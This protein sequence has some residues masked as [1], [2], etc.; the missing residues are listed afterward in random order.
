[1]FYSWIIACSFIYF[2]MCSR[3]LVYLSNC[4]PTWKKRQADQLT[5]NIAKILLKK[6]LEAEQIISETRQ[7]WLPL[8][9]TMPHL[10]DGTGIS[11]DLTP[12]ALGGGP[13]ECGGPLERDCKEKKKLTKLTEETQILQNIVLQRCKAWNFPQKSKFWCVERLTESIISR[14]FC[15][16]SSICWGSPCKRHT[17]SGPTPLSAMNK[18][19]RIL[20][21][22]YETLCLIKIV[23]LKKILLP[24]HLE[25]YHRNQQHGP[26][27]T[28]HRQAKARKIYSFN[29]IATYAL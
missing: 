29:I 9:M 24:Q 10:W 15:V 6:S 7:L 27:L 18:K 2:H 28:H 22:N 20:N 16:A 14:I 4:F 23:F 11:M 17:R 5:E 3:N 25:C 1:M 8:P 21:H 12:G 26:K 19:G 13:R